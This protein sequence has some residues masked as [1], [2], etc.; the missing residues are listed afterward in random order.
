MV[1]LSVLVCLAATVLLLPTVSDAISLLR[2][3]LG[4]GAARHQSRAELPRLLLLVTAHNEE[5]LIDSCVRSLIA[6]DYPPARFSVV[7]IAD[8]CTDRTADLARAASARC[9][10]RHDVEHPGK[11]RAVAWALKQLPLG[12]YDAVVIVDA[13]AV[14]DAQFATALAA[15][16]PLTHKAVQPYNDVRNPAESAVTRLAAVFSTARY[17]GSFVLK[18]RAGVNVPL[19]AGMCIGTAI[20][21]EHGWDAFSIGEDWEWYAILTALGIR[22]DYAPGAHLYAQ[23]AK[24]LAQSAAQRQRWTAGK[25]TVLGRRGPQILRNTQIGLHT[26]IDAIAELSAPGP[27]VHLGVVALLG[28]LT[29]ALTLPLATVLIL[30]LTASVIRPAAYT[31]VGLR[32]DHHPM[33]AALAF[34]FLPIY[35]VWRLAVAVASLRMIGDRPWIRTRRHARNLGAR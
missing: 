10:E 7:V 2:I 18:W 14:V 29:Q 25:L 5:L 20:L 1:V 11:P 4:R 6:L 12:A 16:A 24:S 27:V 35:A 22:I 3:A 33:R 28:V 31:I 15:A 8:N 26:K 32:G 17:R 19:S 34:A 30:A 23:E 13:D 21:T 9:L